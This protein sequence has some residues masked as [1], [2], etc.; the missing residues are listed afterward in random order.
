[1]SPDE[2][3]ENVN[4]FR[5]EM[6]PIAPK[7]TDFKTV[8]ENVLFCLKTF[9]SRSFQSCSKDFLKVTLSTVRKVFTQFVNI[10][11]ANASK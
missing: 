7:L 4:L 11:T 10:M 9:G 2:V 6:Q 5:H 8:E 1:M 3:E